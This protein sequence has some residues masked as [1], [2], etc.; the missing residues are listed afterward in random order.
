MKSTTVA[1]F[2]SRPTTCASRF[3][4]AAAPSCR[5]RRAIR[6]ASEA[7]SRIRTSASGATTV[8]MSRP[9]ATIRNPLSRMMSCCMRTSTSRAGTIVETRETLSVTRSPRIAERTSSPLTRMRSSSGSVPISS[10]TV[11]VAATTASWSSKLT[12][13]SRHHH[14]TARYIAPVSR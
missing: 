6:A 8:V 2:A 5:P 4:D 7:V 11:S 3:D 13:E 14:V 10:G 1:S 12:P 9:S